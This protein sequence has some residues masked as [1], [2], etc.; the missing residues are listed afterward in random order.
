MAPHPRPY[1]PLRTVLCT[2]LVTLALSACASAPATGSFSPSGTTRTDTTPLDSDQAGQPTASS[3]AEI[4]KSAL[5]SYR[6]YHAAVQTAYERNDASGLPNVAID[7]ILRRVT[8]D[9]NET[10]AKGV[11]WRFVNVLSPRIYAQSPDRTTIFIAD[12]LRT[13]AGYR[14]SL[15][16]GKRTASAPGK[17]YVYRTAV[18]LESGRWLVADAVRDREC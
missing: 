17:A 16:T 10:T 3:K 6:A 15:A 18:H 11:V 12:C 13:L 7:P 8:R 14:F 2:S 5:T 4:E 9:V 1:H